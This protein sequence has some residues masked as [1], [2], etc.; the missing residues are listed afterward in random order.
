VNPH[1]KICINSSVARR[2]H[3]VR[4]SFL[5]KNQAQS[6]PTNPSKLLIPFPCS[7]RCSFVLPLAVLVALRASYLTKRASSIK[8]SRSVHAQVTNWTCSLLDHILI[9]SAQFSPDM[10]ATACRRCRK[11]KVRHIS[12]ISVLYE[13]SA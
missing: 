2:R 7:A 9:H 10:R 11:Q 5:A 13:G 3:E 12:N 4:N 6:T 8:F 1:L